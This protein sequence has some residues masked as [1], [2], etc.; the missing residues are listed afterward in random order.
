[1]GVKWMKFAIFVGLLA[2]A[3]SCS[4]AASPP[5]IAST[6]ASTITAAGLCADEHGDWDAAKETCT[7]VVA[8][9]KHMHINISATYPAAL[10]ND[11]TAA[12]GVANQVRKFF[13]EFKNYNDGY[14]RNSEAT[15]NYT[16]YKH[17]PATVS[18]L[19]KTYSFFAGA[20][21]PN[22]RLTSLT[23]D[24]AQAKQLQLA[25][26]FCNGID[27]NTALI[28]LVHPYLQTEI[29]KVNQQR[30]DGSAPLKA[31][32]FEPEPSGA[33][34]HYTHV[35]SYDTWVLD[36]DSL[37]LILPSEREGPVSAGL[38]QPHIPL[39]AL[40]SILRDGGCSA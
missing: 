36:G 5:Q 24:L 21:H 40:R 27:P 19:F 15:L 14:T 13:I 39:S 22:T 37:V 31:R 10:L 11:A 23:F 34:K 7:L 38:L 16:A 25:N 2:I 6:S 32:E 3:A 29:D 28:S 9:A 17:Q 35:D 1:M 4:S 18:V 30:S 26:L 33:E 20:A 8:N 12:T